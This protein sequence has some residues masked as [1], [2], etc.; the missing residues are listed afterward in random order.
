MIFI[1]DRIVCLLCGGT[2]NTIKRYNATKHYL[3]HKDH[4]FVSLEGEARKS[5]LYKMKKEKDKQRYELLTFIN[6][7][8]ASIEAKYEVAYI[9]GKRGK[10]Y[11]DAEMVKEC[12]LAAVKPIDLGNFYKYIQMPLS[13]RTVTERQHELV[14]NIVKKA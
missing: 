13:R 6:Q 1:N 7:K 9:L 4:K 14:C 12:I 8:S 10:P 2:L 11:S 3:S 5:A